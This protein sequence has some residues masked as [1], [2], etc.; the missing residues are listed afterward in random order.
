MRSADLTLTM[1]KM[2]GLNQRLGVTF[3]ELITVLAILS[4]AARQSF[5]GFSALQCL[6]QSRI[7]LKRL[8]FI[9]ENSRITAITQGSTLVL[10]T[11]TPEADFNHELKLTNKDTL[12]VVQ[13]YPSLKYGRL[14]F[15]GSLKAAFL[16]FKSDG[17]LGHQGHFSYFSGN[18]NAPQKEL[19]R[20]TVLLS[21][22]YYVNK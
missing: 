8:A 1:I 19:W 2:K 10:T 6:Y 15:C 11:N 12:E 14:T 16:D 5:T 18:K 17:S 22:H 3:L 9:L 7:A 21:G 4:I 13:H 20:V